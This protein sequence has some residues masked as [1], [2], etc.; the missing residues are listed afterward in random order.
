MRANIVAAFTFVGVASLVCAADNVIIVGDGASDVSANTWKDVASSPTNST[1]SKFTGFDVS[2]DYPGSEQD[3][4]E[5]SV[6]V[7]ENA[8][9][10][11]GNITATVLSISR[12]SNGTFDKSWHFCVYAFTVKAT[13]SYAYFAGQKDSCNNL[14]AAECIDDLKKNAVKNSATDSCNAYSTTPSCLRDLDEEQKAK[15]LSLSGKFHPHVS[16]KYI[17]RPSHGTR[18]ADQSEPV[19]YSL[20]SQ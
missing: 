13:S 3:G 6:D 19:R 8:K 4:W 16:K 11:N 7:K 12:P 17:S 14:V 15:V 10:P 2:M 1:T 20:N 9:G 18:I 5:L